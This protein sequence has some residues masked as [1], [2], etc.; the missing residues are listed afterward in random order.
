MLLIKVKRVDFDDYTVTMTRVTQMHTERRT[1][2][3][4]QTERLSAHQKLGVGG[5]ES[6][7][8]SEGTNLLAP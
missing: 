5:A 7:T 3:C 2:M 4:R 6:L 8:A 1:P